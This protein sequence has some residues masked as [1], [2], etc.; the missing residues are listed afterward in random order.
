MGELRADDPFVHALETPSPRQRAVLRSRTC[1]SDRSRRGARG[2][3]ARVRPVRPC[4][5]LRNST[6][7]PASCASCGVYPAPSV[8]RRDAKRAVNEGRRRALGARLSECACLRDGINPKRTPAAATATGAAMD[9]GPIRLIGKELAAGRAIGYRF[10]Q[11]SVELTRSE[12]LHPNSRVQRSAGTDNHRERRPSGGIGH[13][14]NHGA[15][16]FTTGGPIL[17]PRLF[18]QCLPKPF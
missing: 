13:F 7:S 1:R 5:R 16:V 11:S 10:R 18:H 14:R 9:V 17:P 15:G 8:P 3:R 4:A 6:F 2:A 12:Q